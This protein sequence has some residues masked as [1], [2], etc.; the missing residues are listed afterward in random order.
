MQWEE[1]RGFGPS[2]GSDTALSQLLW[3]QV[4]LYRTGPVVPRCPV[5][6]KK[7]LQIVE[8]TLRRR[9]VYITRGV[10][11]KAQGGEKVPKAVFTN[12]SHVLSHSWSGLGELK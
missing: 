5:V 2:L 3:A 8:G 11:N 6:A 10:S 1:R 7:K 9:N 12:V 4:L